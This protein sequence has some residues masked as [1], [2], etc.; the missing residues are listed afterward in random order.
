MHV[1]TLQ[2]NMPGQPA[3]E[4]ADAFVMSP[5]SEGG[6]VLYTPVR[7]LEKLESHETLKTQLSAAG[8]RV[9][10]GAT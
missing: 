8:L 3:I 2:L 6:V 1:Q 10:P 4:L 9:K 7:G 5:A